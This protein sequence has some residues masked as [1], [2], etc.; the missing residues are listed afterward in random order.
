MTDE[1]REEIQA[2]EEVRQKHARKEKRRRNRVY[3]FVPLIAGAAF[4]MLCLAIVQS[5]RVEKAVS[6][7]EDARDDAQTSERR[8]NKNAIRITEIAASQNDLA[9]SARLVIRVGCEADNQDRVI[10]RKRIRR[11]LRTLEE[12]RSNGGVNEQLYQAAVDSAEKD[13]AD[14]QDRDCDAAVEEIP[15]DPVTTGQKPP[16]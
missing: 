1:Q 5:V 4:I 15:L 6:A 16:E 12:L 7:A 9:R 11:G 10:Q 14:Q 8:A 3:Q 2:K 13:L